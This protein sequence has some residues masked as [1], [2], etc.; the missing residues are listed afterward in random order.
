MEHEERF[1]DVLA[2]YLEAVDAGW[3]PPREQLLRRYPQFA[4]E[5]R[6]F[7]GNSDGIE[8]TLGSLRAVTLHQAADGLNGIATLADPAVAA[9]LIPGRSLNDYEILKEVARGGMGVV[10]KARQRS[11]NR[12]VALKM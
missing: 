6:E 8:T 1:G 3:A 9:P 7:F 12:D 5:L 11:L 4:D 10:Y 2:A